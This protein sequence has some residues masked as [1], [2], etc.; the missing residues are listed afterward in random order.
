MLTGNARTRKK[1]RARRSSPSRRPVCRV[2]QPPGKGPA[3]S[4]LG[5]EWQA[6]TP[7]RGRAG[8]LRVR[9]AR[10]RHDLLRIRVRPRGAAAPGNPVR[11]AGASGPGAPRPVAPWPAEPAPQSQGWE[12]PGGQV[13]KGPLNFRQLIR[14][15]RSGGRHLYQSGQYR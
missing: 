13:T 4:R 14:P 10:P 8:G 5:S 12:K 7:V 11:S 15:E 3:E 1:D 9:E 6:P 2:G